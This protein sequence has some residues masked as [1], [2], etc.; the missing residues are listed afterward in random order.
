MS[1]KNEWS[2]LKQR[3]MVMS[4]EAMVEPFCQWVDVFANEENAKGGLFANWLDW[5]A[6]RRQ[7]A[8]KAILAGEIYK[9]GTGPQLEG[10]MLAAL[11][12][13]L[14]FGRV[15]VATSMQ[16]DGAVTRRVCHA[17]E[18]LIGEPVKHI[19]SYTGISSRLT[20]PDVVNS[21]YVIA[22]Y[23]MLMEA[24]YRNG[25]AFKKGMCIM[26]YEADVALYCNRLMF[27][28]RGVPKCAGMAYRMRPELEGGSLSNNNVF[29][30][31]DGLKDLD[32]EICGSSSYMDK[33]S[34]EQLARQF[35]ERIKVKPTP[36]PKAKITAMAYRTGAE[37][38]NAL[39]Q[40]M[41]KCQDDVLVFFPE[42][43]IGN[44]LQEELRKSGQSFVMVKDADEMA[45]A[46]ETGTGKHIILESR[47][48]TTLAALPREIRPAN[49]FIA[50]LFI[51][52]CCYE[53]IRC[54]AERLTKMNG[55]IRQY[56]SLDDNIMKVYEE[57]GG[58]EKFFK[59]MDFTEKYDSW[60]QVRRVMGRVILKRLDNMRQAVLDE[61]LPL[62]STSFTGRVKVNMDRGK[63]GVVNKAAKIGEG[64]CFCGSGKPFKEC[65]GKPRS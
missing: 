48:P 5:P 61:T 13:V 59:I 14:T 35:G 26:F 27:M 30:I 2:E 44:A 24:L 37:R 28:D 43:T 3:A 25:A 54:T 49:I 6:A 63:P 12:H 33:Q 7:E 62:I 31:G 53:K 45:T 51:N 38:M 55:N 52:D 42:D 23:H 39:L 8:L 41:A 58:F 46:L 18:E 4:R 32:I 60:C 29:D 10:L 36:S 11:Y 22:D 40:D 1:A 17:I 65:H 57:Q 16:L 21:Q 19:G 56:F 47:M 15:I 9:F 50:G 34:A 20:F 64:L